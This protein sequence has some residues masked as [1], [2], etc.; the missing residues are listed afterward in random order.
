MKIKMKMSKTPSII[1]NVVFILLGIFFIVMFPT[2]Y[3]QTNAYGIAGFSVIVLMMTLL[4]SIVYTMEYFSVK[5]FGFIVVYYFLM[6]YYAIINECFQLSY[7]YYFLFACPVL[8]LFNYC[9]YVR[10]RLYK[11]LKFFVLLVFCVAV[12]SLFFWLF[13]SVFEIIEP[14]GRIRL[15]WNGGRLVDNYYNLYIE[16]QIWDFDMTGMHISFRNCGFFCEA[17]VASFCF[18][19]ALLLNVNYTKILPYLV[20][21]VLIVAI[22]STFST[23]GFIVLLMLILQKFWS[24]NANTS[25]KKVFKF[26][27]A[28][29]IV[30]MIFFLGYMAF[31]EKMSTGSGHTRH[32][33]I[34]RN[35][36]AFM[37][38][39]FIGN[40]FGYIEASSNSFAVLLADGGLLLWGLY[41]LPG[42]ILLLRK[43]KDGIIDWFILIYMGMFL[44]T[45]VQYRILT[46]IWEI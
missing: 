24:L 3:E 33:D 34:R 43:I 29:L 15:G 5:V 39:P 6:I 27:F 37:K 22:L 46:S 32:E 12:I 11:F 25:I 42:I 8:I 9:L 26:L 20:N 7:I 45:I 31:S 16:P 38:H 10:Q 23:T 17:P 28:I 19:L 35:L 18:S 4:Y 14:T 40:G 13:A 1:E 2:M 21:I 36:G 30:S 44:I 41:Y